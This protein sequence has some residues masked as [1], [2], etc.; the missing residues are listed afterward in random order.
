MFV[1]IK[2]GEIVETK[3]QFN[4]LMKTN[5]KLIKNVNYDSKCYV[6]L[7]CAFE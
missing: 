3:S 5:K 1:I 4:V 7:T 2:K 6:N